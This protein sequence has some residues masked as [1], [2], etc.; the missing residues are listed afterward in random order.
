[1]R[2]RRGV[3]WPYSEIFLPISIQVV[4]WPGR[5]Y[6]VGIYDRL[7]LSVFLQCV[8]FFLNFFLST[9]SFHFVLFQVLWFAWVDRIIFASIIRKRLKGWRRSCRTLGFH[10]CP[11]ISPMLR[12]LLESPA[13]HHQ[14]L[15]LSL[16][17]RFFLWNVFHMP[18]DN[19]FQRAPQSCLSHLKF[20][21]WKVSI[22]CSNAYFIP[23]K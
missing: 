2:Q 20:L 23:K 16:R 6:G 4:V 21:S 19:V 12:Q 15:P 10:P 3:A 9:F 7:E 14:Q 8:N 13:M 22:H 11:W 1:M 18:A 5:V 17:V